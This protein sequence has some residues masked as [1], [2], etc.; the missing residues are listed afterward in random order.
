MPSVEKSSNK[1]VLKSPVWGAEPFWMYLT[2][3]GVQIIFF[4]LILLLIIDPIITRKNIFI[5]F[6]AV[7][8]NYIIT[9]IIS[10]FGGYLLVKWIF[11]LMDYRTKPITYKYKGRGAKHIWKYL[12]T[13]IFQSVFFVLAV[14]QYVAIRFDLYE[15]W[16]LVITWII[17][18]IIAKLLGKLIYVL[19]AQYG[20]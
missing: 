10:V 8:L 1:R 11:N 15:F 18:A 20:V 4:F 7:L 14:Y 2:K 19:V 3:L 17:L 6:F 12:F 13:C 16:A 9:G 5:Y